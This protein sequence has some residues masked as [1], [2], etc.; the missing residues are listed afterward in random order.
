MCADPTIKTAV[1]KGQ[2]FSRQL[3]GKTGRLSLHAKPLDAPHF[4]VDVTNPSNGCGGCKNHAMNS[5]V[6][7][8]KAWRTSDGSS[9]WLRSTKYG[10][11]SGNY[12][13]NCYLNV[14]AN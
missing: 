10:E 5:R 6:A 14:R 11:P 3:A 12:E 2:S 1:P 7:Q 13:A 8:Q 4:I 9:W